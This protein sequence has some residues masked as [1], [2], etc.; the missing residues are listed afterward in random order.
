MANQRL[1]YATQ[2]VQQLKTAAPELTLGLT[3]GTQQQLT[4]LDHQ[5]QQTRQTLQLIQTSISS[6]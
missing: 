6:S 2:Q 4:Q 1:Q 3:K 5:I